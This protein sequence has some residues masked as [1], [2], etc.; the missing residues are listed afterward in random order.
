M[1]VSDSPRKI[2]LKRPKC[3]EFGFEGSTL[4]QTDC[5]LRILETVVDVVDIATN[6]WQAL[7]E[8][9]AGY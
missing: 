6:V 1:E 4:E 2:R 7:S 5:C 9:K 3:T 8:P